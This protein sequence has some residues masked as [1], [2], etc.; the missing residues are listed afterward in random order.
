MGKYASWNQTEYVFQ[1]TLTTRPRLFMR[2]IMINSERNLTCDLMWAV[3]VWWSWGPRVR[4]CHCVRSQRSPEPEGSTHSLRECWILKSLRQTRERNINDVRLRGK[5]KVREETL[6][7]TCTSQL[8]WILS[9]LLADI[10][11]SL[12]GGFLQNTKCVKQKVWEKKPALRMKD[13]NAEKAAAIAL[14]LY[15]IRSACAFHNFL[16]ALWQTRTQSG[17]CKIL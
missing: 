13:N 3:W 10:S 7:C 2:V 9:A 17:N 11:I 12:W 4:Y 8:T 6:W 1:I 16:K 14:H 5:G 15:L